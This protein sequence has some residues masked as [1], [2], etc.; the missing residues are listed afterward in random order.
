MMVATVLS[1]RL[2][3]GSGARFCVC[4]GSHFRAVSGRREH[5]F[6]WWTRIWRLD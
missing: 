4:P 2:A 5:P 6:V 3:F 1:M